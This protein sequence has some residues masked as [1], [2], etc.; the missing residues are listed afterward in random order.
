MSLQQQLEITTGIAG[1][2]T[3]TADATASG[4]QRHTAPRRASLSANVCNLSRFSTWPSRSANS[5]MVSGDYQSVLEVGRCGCG[6]GRTINRTLCDAEGDRGRPRGPGG[7]VASAA[8]P[9]FCG[10]VAASPLFV[11]R[12][13]SLGVQRNS[14][15][16]ASPD[17]CPRAPKGSAAVAQLARRCSRSLD[18]A[19]D[20]PAGARLGGGRWILG[21]PDATRPIPDLVRPSQKSRLRLMATAVTAFWQEA[22]SR[23]DG[24][25]AATTGGRWS[26][27]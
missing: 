19:V 10:A 1:A 20:A 26:I 11:Q 18:E 12:G 4:T 6:C 23:R 2:A 27:R 22:W 15:R 9:L 14:T 16:D 13:A 5:S 21:R 24:G 3:A 8:G 25:V 17:G 7:R